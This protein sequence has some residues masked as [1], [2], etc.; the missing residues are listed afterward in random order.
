MNGFDVRARRRAAVLVAAAVTLVLSGLFS[1]PALALPVG[2]ATIDL[3]ETGQATGDATDACL[4]FA[5]CFWNYSGTA[6]GQPFRHPVRV[7]GSIDGGFVYDSIEACFPFATGVFRF[8]DQRS[9]TL[10]LEKTVAGE[11]CVT[12]PIGSHFQHTFTG[13]YA[14]TGSHGALLASGSGTMTLHDNLMTQTFEATEQGQ[15]VVAPPGR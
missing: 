10:L 9:G 6:G 5:T 15:L 2:A 1:A 12:R 8:Y 14:V 13:T 7:V 3:V 11:Y 4:A